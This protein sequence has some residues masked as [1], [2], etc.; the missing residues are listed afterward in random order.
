MIKFCI[1]FTITQTH[2]VTEKPNST[3]TS[4]SSVSTTSNN[5]IDILQQIFK[6]QNTVQSFG[7]IHVSSLLLYIVKCIM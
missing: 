2:A 3:F 1:L 6:N 7:N 5:Q 4:T